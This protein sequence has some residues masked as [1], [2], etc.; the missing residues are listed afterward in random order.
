M[1]IDSYWWWVNLWLSIAVDLSQGFA[2]TIFIVWTG[3]V[4]I[5]SHCEGA[6]HIQCHSCLMQHYTHQLHVIHTLDTNYGHKMRNCVT[7]IHK[8]MNLVNQDVII[9]NLTFTSLLLLLL[10]FQGIYTS[11]GNF[12]DINDTKS[13]MKTPMLWICIQPNTWKTLLG[14][15][16]FICLYIA[17][18]FVVCCTFAT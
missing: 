17:W 5:N 10:L 11:S 4:R 1:S 7:K 8:S 14:T 6:K 12:K 15:L 2:I 13:K 3:Q 18:I 16:F 9:R